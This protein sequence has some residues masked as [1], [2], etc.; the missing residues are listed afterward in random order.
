MC[1]VLPVG[2]GVGVGMEVV[3]VT[4]EV[5]STMLVAGDEAGVELTS[6]IM[7]HTRTQPDLYLSLKLEDYNV[8]QTTHVLL[9]I[10][11]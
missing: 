10:H 7:T 11:I 5:V 1:S 3:V 6:T 8:H 4:G 9:R 2:D